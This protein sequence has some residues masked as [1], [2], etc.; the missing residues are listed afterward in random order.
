VDSAESVEEIEQRIEI[1]LLRQDILQRSSV[2]ES[3]RVVQVL[4]I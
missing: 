2:D 4:P 3:K 1:E